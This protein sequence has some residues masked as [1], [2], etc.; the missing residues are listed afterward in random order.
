MFCRTAVRFAA[1]RVPM[2]LDISSV[3]GGCSGCD[4][5]TEGGVRGIIGG[6]EGATAEK[7]EGRGSE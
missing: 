1:S 7:G 5:G 3:P 6:G 2:K 4:G